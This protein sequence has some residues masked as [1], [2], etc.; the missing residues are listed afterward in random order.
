MVS[1]E[2]RITNIEKAMQFKC[3]DLPGMHLMFTGEPVLVLG[4]VN[5]FEANRKIEHEVVSWLL[6]LCR[7]QKN[8]CDPGRYRADA[9]EQAFAQRHDLGNELAEWADHHML[10]YDAEEA[11]CMTLQSP[12]SGE[13]EICWRF[14]AAYVNRKGKVIVPKD[15]FIKEVEKEKKRI[16]SI[17]SA[18]EP[19][20]NS[21][22]LK[23]LQ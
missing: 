18:Y 10:M 8:Y 11:P 6:W 9:P 21:C 23:E 16:Y 14:G 3:Y 22:W 13:L 1:L 15:D 2:L 12:S 20:K 7:E 19:L 17:L 4:N 5:V